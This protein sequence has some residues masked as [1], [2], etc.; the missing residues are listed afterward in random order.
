[1]FVQASTQIDRPLARSTA[2][3]EDAVLPAL[4]ALVRDSWRTPEADA[5][6]SDGNA[7]T[8]PAVSVTVGPRRHRHDGVVYALTWP[9]VEAFGLPEFDAD[10]ELAPFGADRTHLEMEGR[11][12]YLGVEPWSIEERRMHR[13]TT[14]A[15]QRLLHR[16][17]DAIERSPTVPSV[18]VHEP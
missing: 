5:S 9:G 18:G 13:M 17:S 14:A 2:A 3:F 8:F 1:V 12:R 7:T 4:A 16:M 6:D 15:L 10:I 11:C